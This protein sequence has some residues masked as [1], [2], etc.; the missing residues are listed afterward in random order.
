MTWTAPKGCVDHHRGLLERHVNSQPA[1]GL[2]EPVIGE[3]FNSGR[4]GEARLQLYALTQGFDV[5]TRGGGNTRNS[6][7]EIRCIHHSEKTRNYRGLEDR[8]IRDE[9]GLIVSQRKREGTNAR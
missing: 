3:V 1:A 6:A 9:E 2:E 4:D 8:V 5:V 7:A